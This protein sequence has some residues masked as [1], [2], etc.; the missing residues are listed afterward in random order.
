M[1]NDFCTTLFF[2]S[3]EV[4]HGAPDSEVRHVGDLGNIQADAYG[5]ANVDITDSII[6]LTGRHSIIGRAIVV[7]SG[8]DDLG[9]GGSPLSLT[10]GNSGDRWACGIIGVL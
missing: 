1:I 9:R 5:E 10:T 4:A 3:F 8:K 7:H 2:L 6:S